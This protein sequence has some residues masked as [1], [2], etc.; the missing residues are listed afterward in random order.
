MRPIARLL[1]AAALLLVLVVVALCALHPLYAVDFFWHLKLGELI[2]A[3]RSIPD[4]NLFGAEPDRPYVQ[5]NWLWELGAATWVEHF[6]LR[7]VRIAQAGLMTA[8]IG[9]LYALARVRLKAA[10]P[11]LACAALG[12]VLFE[13]RFQERPAALALGFVMLLAC[14]FPQGPRDPA[15]WSPRSLLALAGLGVLWS[16][17][18][19]GESL[20]L[21][22]SL[23][24]LTGGAM[25]NRSLLGRSDEPL[26]SG[27]LALAVSLGAL[28]LSPTLLPGLWSWLGTI[29][30]QLQ[31]GNEEWQPTY[32]MLVQGARP[33]FIV[34]ALAPTVVSTMFVWHHARSYRRDGREVLDAR[35]LLLCMGYLVLAQQAVRNAF[36]CVVPLLFVLPRMAAL[37]SLRWRSA[38]AL[39]SAA[40]ITIAAEDALAYSYG[41]WARVPAVMQ[42][43]L[44]PDSVPQ[45][46]TDMMAEAGLIGGVINDGRFG[47]YLIWRLWPRC[48]VFADSRHHF[49][50]EMWSIFRASH[51]PLARPAALERAFARY[52][53]ELV[54]FRGPVFP[55]GAPA[56]YRLLYRA[57]DQEVYQDLRGRNAARN[58]Q[59]TRGWLAQH[60]KDVP[61]DPSDA[62]IPVLAAQ[63]GQR[64]FLAT[65]YH[66]LLQREIEQQRQS[67]EPASV[68]AGDRALARLLYRAGA[69]TQATPH[70]AR[71]IAGAPRDAALRYEAGQNAFALGD[72][73][74]T[75]ALLA[76]A[77]AQ[78]SGLS[79]RQLRRLIAI[80]EVARAQSEHTR[81]RS[82]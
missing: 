68:L 45:L 72:Y 49:D 55:L 19:G 54:V 51:D 53:S 77:Q 71:A 73:A 67:G 81:I 65:P 64:A 66:R 74:Q 34:I 35:E 20:L 10:E 61:Q 18:H 3:H 13:D 47:G 25:I 30:P 70:Y 76:S 31:S 52:G 27:V 78:P 57:G 39:M 11:A 23:L 33:S 4:T 50:A 1:E 7:G 36:L 59:R 6:G 24:A 44:A 60:M 63:L 37:R 82:R 40:L 22:L 12:C 5:F 17:L 62:A 15:R 69:N 29:G 56:R 58:L 26:A 75:D 21:P 28:A 79:A 48:S 38:A 2:A 46:A 16:N 43:D 41:G 80:R 32:R 9:G 42:L 14:F 8:S